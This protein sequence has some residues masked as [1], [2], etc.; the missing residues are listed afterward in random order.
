MP[1]FLFI[2]SVIKT[3]AFCLWAPAHLNSTFYRLHNW[4]WCGLK[5][6]ELVL[7]DTLL[8][9][10]LSLT[11]Q[12][13]NCNGCGKLKLQNV[14]NYSERH[15]R[16]NICFTSIWVNSLLNFFSIN[17]WSLEHLRGLIWKPV[18]PS[19]KVIWIIKSKVTNMFVV[20][21]DT[22]HA[23]CWSKSFVLNKF[24]CIFPSLME[25]RKESSTKTC[26]NIQ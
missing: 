5:N 1:I 8:K 19:V 14:K 10:L 23:V 16:W 26:Q 12:G 15:F 18:K 9:V 13:T 17:I 4:L 22:P 11:G 21:F 20:Y 25:K 3:Y 24:F 6:H 2:H 7:V